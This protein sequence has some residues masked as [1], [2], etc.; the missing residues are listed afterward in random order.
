MKKTFNFSMGLVALILLF[1]TNQ[2][3]AQNCTTALT[4]SITTLQEANPGSGD[5]LVS[6]GWDANCGVRGATSTCGPTDMNSVFWYVGFYGQ[7][8][9]A[10]NGLVIECGVRTVESED[11]TAAGGGCM[12]PGVNELPISNGGTYPVGDGC[13]DSKGSTCVSQAFSQRIPAVTG[14]LHSWHIAGADAGGDLGYCDVLP[15]FN[16]ALCPGQCYNVVMW[17]LIID[18]PTGTGDTPDA[19]NGNNLPF[20]GFDNNAACGNITIIDESPASNIMQICMSGTNDAIEN[21]TLTASSDLGICAATTA[22]P[23][24]GSYQAQPADEGDPTLT[25]PCQG[26]DIDVQTILNDADPT[27]DGVVTDMVT[28]GT[29]NGGNVGDLSVTMGAG[30]NP[31]SNGQLNLGAHV[32]EV[33]C[34][35]NM[36]IAFSTPTGCDGVLGFSNDPVLPDVFGLP[37]C[38]GQPTNTTE[39]KVYITNNGIPVAP[40][41]TDAFTASACWANGSNTNTCA[42]NMSSG[43]PADWTAQ[44]GAFVEDDGDFGGIAGQ[45]CLINLAGNPFSGAGSNPFSLPGLTQND[46]G[47]GVVRDVATI[48]VRYEDECDGSKSATCLKFISAAPPLAAIGRAC[49]E[50]CPGANDGQLIIHDVAG[51]SDDPNSDSN[52]A[53][54]L[55]GSGSY[56]VTTI[57]GP[58]MPTFTY[59]GGS[60]WATAANLAPGVYTVEVRDA[61]APNDT[62]DNPADD[63]TANCGA[64][65]PIQVLVEVLA[66]PVLTTTPMITAVGGC[67]APATATLMVDKLSVAANGQQTFTGGPDI[68]N[69]SAIFADDDAS[70]ITVTGLAPAPC[71]DQTQGATSVAE[72]CIQG[73]NGSTS[74]GISA[75]DLY[76]I[77]PNGTN[78]NFDYGTGFGGNLSGSGPADLCFTAELNGGTLGTAGN[79]L[80]GTWTLAGYDG[81]A[82]G[83][84]SWT[85]W[86]ITLNDRLCTEDL[87]IT[88]FC[89]GVGPDEGDGMGAITSVD[90]TITW[91]SSDANEGG[92][93]EADFTYLTVSGTGENDI[94]F[95]AAQAATDGIAPGTTICYDATAY[96]TGNEFDDANNFTDNQGFATT[97]YKGVCCEVTEQVCFTVPQCFACPDLEDPKAFEY[98]LCEGASLPT[99]EGLQ[100]VCPDCPP[101]L[102]PFCQFDPNTMD[103]TICV[104]GVHTWVSDMSFSFQAP[105]GTIIDL[106]PYANSAAAGN[107]GNCNL[108]DDFNNLCFSNTVGTDFNVCNEGTPLSGTFGSFYGTTINWSGLAGSNIYDQGWNVIVGDCVGGDVGAVTN[109]VI[110]F[111]DNGGGMSCLTEPACVGCD[112]MTEVAGAN[113]ANTVIYDSGTVSLDLN[114]NN[115]TPASGAASFSPPVPPPPTLFPATVEW[116]DAM[117]GGNMVATG[118][119]FQPSDMVAGDYTYYAQCICD[120]YNTEGDCAADEIC[121][122]ERTEVVFHIYA[123]DAGAATSNAQVLCCN[124]TVDFDNTTA[125]YDETLAGGISPKHD[126][127]LGYA[128]TTGSHNN[129][130]PLGAQ[131]DLDALPTAQVF[132]AG[133]A[134]DTGDETADYSTT[135][136]GCPGGTTGTFTAGVYAITPFL[137]V[138]VE[139]VCG[140]VQNPTTQLPDL[141]PF[142]TIQSYQFE[143]PAE[144]SL[145]N[146]PVNASGGNAILTV[147][148]L[149]SYT[150]INGCFILTGYFIDLFVNGTYVATSNAG[151]AF[152]IPIT[153]PVTATIPYTDFGVFNSNDVLTVQI[154]PQVSS[155]MG[156]T[157]D[158]TTLLDDCLLF[159][160][161]YLCYEFEYDATFDDLGEGSICANF[162]SSLDFV[163]LDPICSAET[164]TCNPDGTY[165]V[166]FTP[167]GGLSGLNGASYVDQAT[168]MAV[169]IDG[170]Y[171]I[172]APGAVAVSPVGS[173][174][175]L[176]T[177]TGTGAFTVTYPTSVPMYTIDIAN[178]DINTGALLAS[179]G[180]TDG[181]PFQITG[182]ITLPSDPTTTGDEICEGD[183]A[184][185]L[186]ADC[187]GNSIMWFADDGAGV[188]DTGAGAVAT[189]ASFSPT[190]T[191]PGTYTY[192]AICQDALGCSSSPVS[193]TYVINTLE[194]AALDVPTLS[195]ANEDLNLNPDPVGGIYSG[196]GASFVDAATGTIVANYQDVM[197][198]N[199]DYTLTYTVAGTGG[200]DGE[201]T[202]TFS[203]DIDCGADGGRFDE[204]E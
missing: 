94:S 44:F 180:A 199:V 138:D 46:F 93:T 156:V 187:G 174:D 144:G 115:C 110:T 13:L 35:E 51:G 128:I 31:S 12:T 86:E 137:S 84:I 60:T 61:E 50:T 146:T 150:D 23:Y 106:A 69:V 17:E 11:D 176:T 111:A 141:S 126:Y 186:S 66:G 113:N 4:P 178:W 203:F 3:N 67:D 157:C 98:W 21:P 119:T 20:S 68:E 96:V 175:G 48:C 172:S 182:M 117:T 190:D 25:D 169:T 63:N 136:T 80:N 122:S 45:N 155:P 88:T 47:D 125:M 36:S 177:G 83:D 114:D 179:S 185:T 57:S 192:Y 171:Q 7:N 149:V 30:A 152:P 173:G 127:E 103:I 189:T 87:G 188:P 81:T 70:D 2:V 39:A 24:T 181:C 201:T 97:C 153:Y 120:G 131:G 130:A 121:T 154:T 164:F 143:I 162:G 202:I 139:Q 29:G 147:D 89:G 82:G 43:Y 75:L 132:I 41:T 49:N 163:V 19:N 197:V 167:E 124:E 65:C 116:Y 166:T 1:Y 165:S 74:N 134:N 118:N 107:L 101:N 198:A 184:G 104:T 79:D 59:Q 34:R 28:G 53:D 193:A 109:A 99:G 6:I 123:Q 9:P 142:S 33:N 16:I 112:G 71:V 145:N 38:T 27:W 140:G 95:D 151:A 168:G 40:N 77:D 195:C 8:S 73:L 55:T 22:T 72:I 5:G 108:G 196:S 85:G 14:T 160:S 26:Q 18:Q 64:A 76:L 58:S 52:Y 135:C 159:I 92:T 170:E 204:D 194:T 54:G 161:S 183:A 100:A 42:S 191:T 78:V 90:Q 32:I 56:S 158:E 200:C 37:G 15:V 10:P 129:M 62:F 102:P 91:T 105:N 133:A 148:S